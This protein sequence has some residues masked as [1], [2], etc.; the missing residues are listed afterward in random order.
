MNFRN[1]Q[2]Q[3]YVGL[4]VLCL[5]LVP[6]LGCN[7]EVT[8]DYASLG[9]AEV[10]GTIRLD[11]QPLADAN[12]M[13]EAPDGTFSSGRTNASGK[14]SLMFNSEQS[15][16]MTGEKIVRIQLGKTFSDGEDEGRDAE[17]LPADSREL[18]RSYNI[19]SHLAVTVNAGIQTIDFDLK[20]D[21]CTTSAS[22]SDAAR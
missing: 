4:I 10:S 13:F 2:C 12:V 11:D 20:S 19:E 5:G 9:L 15:G 22:Q 14:Y 16:V 17:P 21:G 6:A 18:P 3:L 1:R 8:P 7:Q